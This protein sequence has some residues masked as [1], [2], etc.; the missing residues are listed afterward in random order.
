MP[1]VAFFEVPVLEILLIFLQE[2]TID[3]KKL[4]RTLSVQYTAAYQYR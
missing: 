3:I 1:A 2:V 4:V